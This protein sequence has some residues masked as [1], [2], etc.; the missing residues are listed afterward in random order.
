[1]DDESL[2]G[3]DTKSSA[4]SMEDEEELEEDGVED[5]HRDCQGAANGVAD[6][7]FKSKP[8]QHLSVAMRLKELQSLL[9][10]RAQHSRRV[11]DAGAG[12]R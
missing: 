4:L 12:I 9:Q 5:W 11:P 6:A 3:G 7:G 10:V 2:N 1:M 8:P